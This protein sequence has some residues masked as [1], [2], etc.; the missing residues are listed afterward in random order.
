M[1]VGLRSSPTHARPN[2]Q[3]RL[4]WTHG[5]WLWV[6]PR[7]YMRLRAWVTGHGLGGALGGLS[8]RPT[9]PHGRRPGWV[10]FWLM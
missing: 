2:P 8:S 4:T 7:M 6:F 3:R 10:G 9:Q 5:G 1:E